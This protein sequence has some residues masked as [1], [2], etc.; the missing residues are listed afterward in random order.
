VFV[1]DV[2][3]LGSVNIRRLWVKGLQVLERPM[4]SRTSLATNNGSV[5]LVAFHAIIT[6]GWKYN[7]Q[8]VC[9]LVSSC[10]SLFVVLPVY[11][12][13][14]VAAATGFQRPDIVCMRGSQISVFLCHFQYFMSKNDTFHLIFAIFGDQLNSVT[15]RNGILFQRNRK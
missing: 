9:A 15:I 1:W 3:W 2:A 5:T 8:H 12:L 6:G 4:D 11:R 10:E 14:T 13:E 7:R